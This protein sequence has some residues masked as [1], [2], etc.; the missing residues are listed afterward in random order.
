MEIRTLEDV[1]K[2]N[3]YSRFKMFEGAEKR[4]LC[5][6]GSLAFT[7]GLFIGLGYQTYRY[8]YC[9]QHPQDAIYALEQWDGTGHPTGPW[10]VRKGKGGDLRN[11]ELEDAVYGAKK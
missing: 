1:L 10:I 5:G 8:R 6:I 2:E 7:T 4:G 11:P 3:G 9:Y